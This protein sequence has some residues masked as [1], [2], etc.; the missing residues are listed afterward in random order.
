MHFDLHANDKDTELGK[1]LT[2]AVVERVIRA[3]RPEYIQYDSKGHCGYLGYPHSKVSA[4]A[5]GPDGRGIIKDS[6]A[7]YR[8]VT[9]RHGIGLYVHF[10][11]IWD[12][13]ASREHP[14]WTPCDEKG[15]RRNGPAMSTFGPYLRKRM[16]P[17]MVELLQRYD[18]DGFWVDGDGWATYIDY[19]PEAI[20]RFR[21]VTGMRHPP[22]KPGEPG[23][24]AWGNLQRDQF[25]DYVRT[26]AGELHRRKPGI[27]ICSNYLGSRM[28]PIPAAK[29][30]TDFLSGDFGW[31]GAVNVGRFDA[32]H[33]SGTG[34]P[35]DLMLWGFLSVPQAGAVYKPAVQLMQESA[36]VLAQG[37]GMQLY[38]SPDRD[39]DFGAHQLHAMR[40][41]SRFARARKAV[42]FKTATVPQV[43]VL[44][45]TRSFW[46]RSPALFNSWGGEL[47]ALL[48]GLHLCIE[49][50]SSVD[51]LCDHQLAARLGHYA[52]VVVPEWEEPDPATVAALK[53]FARDGGSLW[54]LGAKTAS[55]FRD[56]LGVTFVGEPVATP[57]VLHVGQ[58]AVT[59]PGPWQAVRPRSGTK[60]IAWRTFKACE[61]RDPHPA[62]TLVRCG[63]GKIAATFGSL[64]MGH[65]L[66]HAPATRDLARVVLG[67]LCRPLVTLL[68]GDYGN[69]EV[70]LRRKA[71]RLIVH[72]L[73]ANNM[74]TA[75]CSTGQD[76]NAITCAGNSPLVESVPVIGPLTLRLR[77]ATRPTRVTEEPGGKRLEVR[78]AGRNLWDIMVP[79]LHIHVAV[80]A[81][82]KEF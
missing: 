34:R 66:T 17:Q 39:G 72:L 50:G 67:E 70:V 26:Y 31:F 46:A 38:Y 35:W 61:K 78:P 81:E 27:Q 18:V 71:N 52:V 11:G 12:E 56:I 7:I 32:R 79:Q 20:A 44:S 64:A 47:R 33:Y 37:G 68:P 9:R 23:W 62:T 4:T 58:N 13:V 42:C 55:L 2:E 77:S 48:G 65:Y 60:V 3:A 28:S 1:N 14:E 30:P 15:A 10:S 51:I 5:G 24:L 25:V 82:I 6:L 75:E 63:K 57:A 22:K 43:A 40:K 54:L 41:V 76:G 8:R 69:V 29:I 53:Q 73:N 19:C 36:V 74:A 16:L 80:V 59:V 21:E 45:D 49:T